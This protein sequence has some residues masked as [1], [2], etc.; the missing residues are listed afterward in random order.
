MVYLEQNKALHNLNKALNLKQTPWSTW[1][2]TNPL[3]LG[4]RRLSSSYSGTSNARFDI[5]SEES[6]NTEKRA[7]TVRQKPETKRKLSPPRVSVSMSWILCMCEKERERERELVIGLFVV[8]SVY[9][10]E[11]ELALAIVW[12][13]FYGVNPVCVSV[14]EC[15]RQ[16]K[17]ER[18]LVLA[19]VWVGLYVVNPVCVCVCVSVCVCASERENW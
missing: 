8:H 16:R 4:L 2:R 9:M 6:K 3:T 5:S 14:C 12:V 13:S 1:N 10:R 19:I 15:V 18:K 11:R 7:T 17:R